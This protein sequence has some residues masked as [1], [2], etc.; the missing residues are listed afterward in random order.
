MARRIAII[1][2][3]A[4]PEGILGGVDQGGQNLYVAQVARHLRALGHHVDIFTRRDDERKLEVEVLDRGIGL[5]N[6]PAGPARWIPKEDLYQY[7]P[8]FTL[9]MLKFC[10]AQRKRYD[11]IHA[12]FWMSGLV[13]A[14]LKQILNI[15]FVITFHA[16]GRVRRLYQGDQDLFPDVRFEVEDRIVAEANQIVAECP[17]DRSD[18]ISF[19]EADSHRITMVPCGF[20][21]EEFQVQD[22]EIARQVIGV[23]PDIPTVLQLGRLVPRKGVDQ[24]I[25]GF[26]HFVRRWKK[27]AQMLIVGGES[28]A[29]DPVLTP[30]I[31]RLQTIAAEEGIEDKVIFC[32][33]KSRKEIV[34]YFSAA[35]VFVSTPWYEPFGITPVEAMACGKPV[36]GSRVGGIKYSVQDGRTGFLVPHDDPEAIGDRLSLL[37]EHPEDL[38]IM[39]QR[40]RTRAYH[41]FTWQK[42]VEQLSRMYENVIFEGMQS[43]SFHKQR[44]KSDFIRF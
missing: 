3:H 26:A 20:D 23:K 2:E 42:V 19:Y 38:L 24:A 27:D 12:N 39:S 22:R 43:K 17:Q 32:G 6:V 11:L 25:R 9:Y 16:L 33:R 14:D 13:A 40:A 15:P 21:P 4:S 30:E 36:V 37:F 34:T 5:I 8:Q 1:S 29:P 18:L 41:Y 44:A 7:M 35:D 10:K 28:E 31:G